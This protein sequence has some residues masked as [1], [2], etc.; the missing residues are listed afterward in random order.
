[1]VKKIPP[2]MRLYIITCRGKIEFCA[3]MF[4][5]WNQTFNGS[6]PSINRRD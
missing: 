4:E 3:A 6:A 5:V 1:M 2:P